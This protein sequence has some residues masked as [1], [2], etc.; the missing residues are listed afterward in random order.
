[1]K[2]AEY[3]ETRQVHNNLKK[4]SDNEFSDYSFV[5]LSG[6]HVLYFELQMDP[7][8]YDRRNVP[9]AE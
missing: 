3:T 7:F 4:S 5:F 6:N 9:Q 2:E 1:M 8:K